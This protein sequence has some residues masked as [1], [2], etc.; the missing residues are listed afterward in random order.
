METPRRARRGDKTT[1]G[2]VTPGIDDTHNNPEGVTDHSLDDFSSN[3][4]IVRV[5][6]FTLQFN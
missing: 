6:L 2:G 4:S 3:N 1:A 5:F